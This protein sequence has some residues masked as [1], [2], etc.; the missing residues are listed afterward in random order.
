MNMKT[1]KTFIY[2][3]LTLAA[4]VLASCVNENLYEEGQPD[5]EN[6]Y[7]VYF[8]SQKNLKSHEFEPVVKDGTA[9]PH[10]LT[11]TVK[12]LKS[13]GEIIVPYTIEPSDIFSGS[14][15]KFLDGQATTTFDITVSADAKIGT[16]Y[17]CNVSIDNPQ[18]ALAYSE[19]KTGMDFSAIVVKWNRLKGPEG[20]E[21]GWWRDD[22]FTELFGIKP[23]IENKE[24]IIEE[25]DDKEGY[26]RV[27]GAYANIWERVFLA[28][29][30]N[31][32]EDNPILIVDASNP[33]KVFIPYQ[34]LATIDGDVCGMVQY[35]DVNLSIEPSE[36]LYGTYSKE[37]GVITF[38][39]DAFFSTVNGELWSYGNHNEW[40][41]IVLPGFEPLDYSMTY[42]PAPSAGGKVEISCTFGSNVSKVKYAVYS[43]KLSDVQAKERASELDRKQDAAEVEAGG[44]VVITISGLEKTGVY[45]LVS[46][47]YSADADDP[48]EYV[49]YSYQ[50]F[51]YIK[52]GDEDADGVALVLGGELNATD[53]YA[54]EGFTSETALEMYLKGADIS[55]AYIRVLRGDFTIYP[56]DVLAQMFFEPYIERDLLKPVKE[57]VLSD[58]NG[59]GYT[60]MQT[61]LVPGTEYT[62]LVYAY[63]GYKWDVL[64]V[65]GQT[66]GDYDIVYDSF[67]YDPD[68][69][70]SDLVAAES[71]AELCGTY[72]FWA[73]DMLD[74]KGNGMRKKIGTVTIE[75]YSGY[76]LIF[77]LTGTGAEAA[78]LE[79]DGV[80]YLYREGLIASMPSL[81]KL[82]Q[83]TP[84]V[85]LQDGK[86]EL[87]LALGY[88]GENPYNDPVVVSYLDDPEENLLMAGWVEG[89][90][91]SRAIAF[92]DSYFYEK[93]GYSFTGV[94]LCGYDSDSYVTALKKFSAYDKPLLVPQSGDGAAS[95]M[96][97]KKASLGRAKDI[98]SP[99][100][101]K[102]VTYE[103]REVAFVSSVSV[104]ENTR[105]SGIMIKRASVAS[106]LKL[107][108]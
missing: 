35:T 89:A 17:S 85:Y 62:M 58:I 64:T 48:D 2:I 80:L 38:P 86:L 11:F 54:S 13:D 50:D 45:T 63:N 67:Y 82:D 59:E 33:D 60:D 27:K 7:G 36:S 40:F 52:A 101:L 18:Y 49:E 79:D 5:L 103:P 73:V 81:F 24:V 10:T 94:G 88:F 74:D 106:E 104:K 22:V 41:R 53:K 97:G 6:C 32:Y 68:P 3:L 55:K 61:G 8:P 99:A 46:A 84:A 92:A 69:E 56:S 75:D 26:F 43:G 23:P 65:L 34:R 105:T 30:A 39:K 78:G 90:D 1:A 20:E 15:I 96:P 93:H 16:N 12:R 107:Y 87:P 102:K 71:L 83:D 51:T 9:Q 76:A 19:Y 66:K 70:Y 47:N 108:E 29:G 28:M 25:R 21:Y 14:E 57:E 72:D 4:G 91:G 77:G 44:D 100:G 98:F 95:G 37:S 42:E 31:S